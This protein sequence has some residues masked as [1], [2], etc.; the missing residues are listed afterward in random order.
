MSC[1]PGEPEYQM[2]Q[3]GALTPE[4]VA[5]ISGIEPEQLECWRAEGLLPATL[6]KA[7]LEP[8]CDE[9]DPD[10]FYTLDDH[11][12]VLA[13]AKLLQLGL[14]EAELPAALA[15]LDEACIRWAVD[16]IPILIKDAFP[17]GLDF[18][19]FIAERWHEDKLGR[20]YEYADVV[21][22]KPGVMSSM[23]VIRGRRVDT[24]TVICSYRDESD[25]E[26]IMAGYR[27]TPYQ[28]RRAVAF[29]RAVR[30]FESSDAP[31]VG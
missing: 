21:E 19:R 31:A 20:L 8:F 6:S 28:I 12:R 9:D 23:P 3:Y 27:L 4:L 7:E 15:R 24:N 5:G 16:L 26:R 1:D 18:D 17:E 13:A 29:E 10:W 11:A 25:I 22:L 14:P 30:D 2:H